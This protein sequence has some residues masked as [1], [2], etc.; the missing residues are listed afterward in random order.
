MHQ[1]SLACAHRWAQAPSL[2]PAHPA[3]PARPASPAPR[4]PRARS[5]CP[6]LAP[7]APRAL[8]APRLRTPAPR[9][10]ALAPC[11]DLA[12]RVATL[13]SDTVQ[14]PTAPTVTIQY[15]VLQYSKLYCKSVQWLEDYIAM[16]KLYCREG[17]LR[18]VCD[19]IHLLYC[20]WTKL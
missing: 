7:S 1:L 12:S 17:G 9:L 4:A 10:R 16:E 19:A 15:I 11:R 3:H 5:Q 8:P 6:A 13:C 2:H 20:D 18:V 14:Q